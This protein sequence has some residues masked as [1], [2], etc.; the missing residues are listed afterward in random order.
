VLHAFLRDLARRPAVLGDLDC[1]LAIADWVLVSRGF[2]PAPEYRGAYRTA[3]EY[4]ALL[5]RDGGILRLID[6]LAKRV[7]AERVKP[8]QAGDF[9]VVKAEGKCWGAI[10]TPSGRW[11]IKANDGVIMSDKPRLIAAWGFR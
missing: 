11:A 9:A 8:P 3:A 2:D 10:R 4:E 5:R 1:C 7:G 6:R